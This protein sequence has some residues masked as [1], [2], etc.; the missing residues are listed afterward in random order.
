MGQE[1]TEFPR[2]KHP[3]DDNSC[4]ED[5]AMN[6]NQN[7]DNNNNHDDDDDNNN[8]NSSNHNHHNNHHPHNSN[9][10]NSSSN[11]S[12]NGLEETD[13]QEKPKGIG[14]I[15]LKHYTF[16]QEE[17]LEIDHDIQKRFRKETALVQLVEQKKQQ[18]AAMRNGDDLVDTDDEACT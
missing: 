9:H 16:T 18:A 11:S 4:H 12:L 17:L 15:P 8:N 5:N 3:D 2:E 13:E 14:R 6:H 7:D 1:P 10:N